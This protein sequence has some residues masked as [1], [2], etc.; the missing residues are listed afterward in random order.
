MNKETMDFF[1]CEVS[2]D[3]KALRELLA[4]QL[5]NER[6]VGVKK[7]L[8]NIIYDRTKEYA[9]R[10]RALNKIFKHLQNQGVVVHGNGGIST[11][12]MLKI[13]RDVLN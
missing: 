8:V 11:S 10:Q 4:S 1:G 5:H 7:L 9:V 3:E 13:M 2:F 6:Y 12:Q